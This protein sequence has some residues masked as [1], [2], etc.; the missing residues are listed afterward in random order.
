MEQ[1]STKLIIMNSLKSLYRYRYFILH[2][3]RSHTQRKH[4][5]RWI[6]SLQPDYLLDHPSPWLTFDAIDILNSLTLKGKKVF[7]Y[8]SGGSTLFWL[9]HGAECVSI[10]HNPDWYNVMQPRLKGM[11]G[12]DYRLVLPEP[13]EDKEALD[14]ADP[15]LYLS[16]L[17]GYSFRNYACQIDSFPDNFFDIV[18]IDGRA[19]PAC[20]MHSVSKIKQG[21]CLVLDDAARSY[22]T[23][24]AGAYLQQFD[25]LE[26]VGVRPTQ[27]EI[28]RTDIYTRLAR[29][30]NP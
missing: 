21:G 22:Y 19:R 28:G 29:T 10:E 24:Q 9:N 15:S 11:A 5:F 13:A 8:G 4:I 27:T 25:R 12:I 2:L 20:I 14:I 3:L 26:F 30:A 17:R 18:L 16:E 23:S 1:P 6:K 7:E